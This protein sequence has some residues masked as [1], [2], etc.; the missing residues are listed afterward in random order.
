VIV[1]FISGGNGRKPP[2]HTRVILFLLEAKS[3]N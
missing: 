1:C 3:T 2:I